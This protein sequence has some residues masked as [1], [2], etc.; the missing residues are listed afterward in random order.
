MENTK[1]VYKLYKW[2]RERTKCE[3]YKV[4]ESLNGYNQEALFYCDPCYILNREPDTA[5]NELEVPNP[6]KV[7]I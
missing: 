6:V 1:M 7:K 2:N 4:F 5:I 3:L